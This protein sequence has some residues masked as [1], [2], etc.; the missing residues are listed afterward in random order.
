LRKLPGQ[1]HRGE[2][3]AGIGLR[4]K[5]RGGFVAA[6]ERQEEA[7]VGLQIGLRV[8]GVGTYQRVGVAGREV[9]VERVGQ[10]IGSRGYNQVRDGIR[11]GGPAAA[12]VVYA[13][14]QR[15]AEVITKRAVGGRK[16]I[17]VE[18]L[19]GNP[20]FG[21]ITIQEIGRIAGEAFE[22]VIGVIVDARSARD[23]EPGSGRNVELY[24]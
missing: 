16:D 19:F 18:L 2:K 17:G 9:R 7:V 13:Q 1:R 15:P 14:Q 20:V 24:R 8:V 22:A 5:R 4:P 23:V 6:R 11:E 12:V 21:E 3:E 10:D